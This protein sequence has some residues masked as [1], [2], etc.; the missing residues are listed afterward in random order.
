MGRDTRLRGRE[1]PSEGRSQGLEAPSRT[2]PKPTR[3]GP[4]RAPGVGNRNLDDVRGEVRDT[5]RTRQRRKATVAQK[6]ARDRAGNRSL[7]APASERER[8]QQRPAGRRP[9]GPARGAAKLA[10]GRLTRPRRTPLSVQKNDFERLSLRDEQGKERTL[11]RPNQRERDATPRQVLDADTRRAVQPHHVYHVDRAQAETLRAARDGTAAAG[12]TASS[13]DRAGL[14]RGEGAGFRLTPQGER[15][16]EQLDRAASRD[17]A[18]Q[19][20]VR[21]QLDARYELSPAQER[22]L[23]DLG[24]FRVAREDAITRTVFGDSER[25]ARQIE[26][27]ERNGLVRGLHQNDAIYLSLTPAGRDVLAASQPGRTNIHTGIPRPAQARHD[28]AAYDAYQHAER[29]IR[30]EGGTVRRVR[31]EEDLKAEIRREAYIS[32]AKALRTSG[33]DIKTVTDPERNL[34]IREATAPLARAQGLPVDEEGGVIYPDMQLEIDRPDGTVGRTNVEVVT[35]H[36]GADSVAAKHS[37]GFQLYLPPASSG[38]RSGGGGV[39]VQPLAE[40]LLDF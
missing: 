12:C 18:R 9:A 36:Y 15:V 26:D 38:A 39:S 17:E 4:G 40:E 21:V 3:E 1:T 20:P 28:A 34:A 7:R 10:Q 29:A 16:L 2:P 14:I 8:H 22:V 31:L 13:L 24:R 30:A 25:A 32:A 37:A 19:G 35:E 23:G 27:L 11:D 5:T 33:L 6:A